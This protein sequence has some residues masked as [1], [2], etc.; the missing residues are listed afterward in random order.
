MEIE[1]LEGGN[2]EIKQPHLIGRVLKSVGIDPSDTNSRDTLASLPL[3]H[4]DLEGFARKLGWNY[5]SLIG[6][7]NYLSGSTRPD[8]S[9]AVRQATRYS[10]CPML[11][12]EKAVMR[13]SRYLIANRDRRIVFKP[14]VKKG[15]ELYVDADFTGNWKMADKDSP[16]NCLSR[17]GPSLS[18]TTAQLSENPSYKQRY[19]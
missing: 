18:T 19:V 16:E 5:H 13:I 3:L 9:M 12:R 1:N 10:N 2:F 6:I 11:A 8:V 17:A 15:L 14:D 7:M 4:K